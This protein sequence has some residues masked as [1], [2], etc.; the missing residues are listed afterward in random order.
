MYPLKQDRSLLLLLLGWAALAVAAL[1]LR[2]LWPLDET[3]YVAVAWDMWQRGDFLVPYLNGAPYS[4][5][6]PLLFW[7]MQAGWALFGVNEWWPRLIAPVLGLLSIPLMTQLARRLQPDS[8]DLAIQA[9]WI[10]CGAL[11]FGALFTLLG[12]DGLLV[13]STLIGMLGIV[14]AAQG[15]LRRGM[16]WLGVAIGLGVLSK[17]P[18]I[19]LHLLP[20]AVF[21]PWW[22]PEVR[23]DKGRWYWG[24]LGAVG[25]GAVIALL[26][27]VPA[28]YFGGAAYRT[29]I[30]WGQTAGRM[31]SSFAHRA[32]LWWY[33]P[34]LPVLLFPWLLWPSLWRGLF[35]LRKAESTSVRFL[36]A[37]IVPVF[38]GFSLVSGKQ[39]RYLL[40]LLPAFALLAAYALQRVQHERLRRFDLLMPSLGF[41]LLAS[42]WVYAFMHPQRLGAA[43]SGAPLPI[44]PAVVFAA[45][46]LALLFASGLKLALR[47]RLLASAVWM[48]ILVSYFSVVPLI[49]PYSDPH[50]VAQYLA[51]L[52][53]RGNALAYWGKY[54]AQFDFTGRL[55]PV[56]EI[57]SLE[58]L[59]A[60][61]LQNPQGRIML[62]EDQASTSASPPEFERFFRGGYLQVWSASTFYAA[63]APGATSPA[64]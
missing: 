46:A 52:Q 21:A 61:L 3:R 41:A 25:L 43:L 26:W 24:V 55:K 32:P 58:S 31:T 16:I 28:A 13:C 36:L 60:W 8:T 17:G 47:L 15:E 64:P 40:P 12:F 59:H 56:T 53:Q 4:Q 63:R 27:A 23:R 14:R 38:I 37:W 45:I 10:Y 34:L 54:H 35:A 57:T 50:P 9:V 62:F 20:A 11:L 39:E 42:G 7:L 51:G 18:V 22:S 44:W 49:A 29:A 1:F 19:L 5:K 2:P 30:F 33:L 48:V 6:P